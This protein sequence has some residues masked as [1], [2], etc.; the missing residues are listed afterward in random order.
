MGDDGV[1]GARR[2]PRRSK[3]RGEVGGGQG[4][5]MGRAGAEGGEEMGRGG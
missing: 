4:E 1:G 2:R 3:V 5:E